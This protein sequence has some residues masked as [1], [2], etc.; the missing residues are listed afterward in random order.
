MTRRQ[1][2]FYI[3]ERGTYYVSE[4]ING[5]KT[6][7]KQMG[8]SD[9]C[10]QDWPEILDGLK[11][12]SSLEGFLRALSRIGGLY[13]SS[14]GLKLPAT[15]LHV[16]HSREEIEAKDQTYGIICGTPGAFLDKQLS[17]YV[18]EEVLE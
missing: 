15:K 7:M 16:V 9:S 6:E 12:V 2:Y 11:N 13:H 10:E 5:D 1:I 4:E 8:L 17:N 18:G 3:A 14:L